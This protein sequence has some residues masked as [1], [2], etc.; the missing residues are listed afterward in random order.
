MIFYWGLALGA[1]VVL[2]M[3][4]TLMSDVAQDF[5]GRKNREVRIESAEKQLQQHPEAATCVGPGP[6]QTRKLFGPQLR[7][8]A[9]DLRAYFDGDDLWLWVRSVWTFRGLAEPYA[10]AGVDCG[11]GVGGPH[12]F[13]WRIVPGGVPI[14]TGSVEGLCD[15]AREN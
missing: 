10:S 8:D 4:A 11:C 14:D 1:P 2:A 15:G 3:I 5:I 12:Q 9:L 7:T 6:N 13:Y